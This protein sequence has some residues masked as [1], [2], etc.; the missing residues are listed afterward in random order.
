MERINIIEAWESEELFRPA[1]SFSGQRLS[2]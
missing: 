2:Q 1:K